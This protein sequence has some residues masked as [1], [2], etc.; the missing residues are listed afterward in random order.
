MFIRSILPANSCHQNWRWHDQKKLFQ[1]CQ[2]FRGRMASD[3]VL[4][5]PNFFKSNFFEELSYYVMKTS[6]FTVI[7]SPVWFSK[8]NNPVLPP[9]DNGTSDIHFFPDNHLWIFWVPNATAAGENRPGCWKRICQQNRHCTWSVGSVLISTLLLVLK[10]LF[11]QFTYRALQGLVCFSSMIS[12]F[13][14]GALDRWFLGIGKSLILICLA[15]KSKFRVNLF[16]CQVKTNCEVL[17]ALISQQQDEYASTDLMEN[18][19]MGSS[20][21]FFK[22]SRVGETRFDLIWKVLGNLWRIRSYHP[23]Y[24]ETS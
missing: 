21:V 6:P 2:C 11:F 24:S 23:Y 20:C 1:D 14:L 4:L 13:L 9:D 12:L 16:E 7:V 3:T 5:K 19:V 15:T 8:K 10:Y 17:W 22:L 18:D